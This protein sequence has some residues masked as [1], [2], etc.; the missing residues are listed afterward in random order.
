MGRQIAVKLSEEKEKEFVKF[1]TDNNAV[2]IYPWS[3]RKKIKILKDLPPAGPYMW[4]FY[5]WNTEFNLNSTFIKIK[6]DY[7]K[8][9]YKYAFHSVGKPVI[10]FSRGTVSRIYWEKYFATSHIEYNIEK[11]EKWYEEVVNWFKKNCKY[12]NGVYVA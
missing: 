9:K 7:Q 10:E 5:I 2:L 3:E 4:S 8:T 1:L 12:K 6:K 11:F